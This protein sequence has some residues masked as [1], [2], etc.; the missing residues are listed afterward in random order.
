[1]ISS[2]IQIWNFSKKRHK[3]FIK[4][5]IFSFIMGIFA[6]AQMGAIIYAIYVLL[7]KQPVNEGIKS[8]V[9]MMIICILG[10]FFT[11]YISQISIMKTGMFMVSDKRMTL[12]N[13]LRNTNLGFFN[14]SSVG[15]IS[16]VLTT[17]LSNVEMTAPISLINVI[18]GFLSSISI[19]IA[20]LIYEWHIGV[21]TAIGMALY[22]FAVNW[23]MK[24]SKRD[25]PRRQCA[26]DNLAESVVSFLQG[27]KV[28]KSFSAKNGDTRLKSTINESRNENIRLTDKSMFS[29]VVTQLSIVLFEVLIIIA[30][31]FLYY[32]AQ[33]ISLDTAIVVIVMSFMIYAP[34]NQAGSI[35]S[36]IGMLDSAMEDVNELESIEQLKCENPIDKMQS[37]EI[38]FDNVC[39]S[40]GEREVLHNISTTIKPES[41]TAIIGPSGSGKSTICKLVPRFWDVTSGTIR[42]GGVDIR[43]IENSELMNKISMVFQNTYLFE[44]TILNN[45]R[46]GKKDATLQEVREAARAAR[47]D[48][49]IMSL[50]NGYDTLIQ[51]GGNSLSGG[52]KQRISIARAILKNAPIIIL[53][54][55]TSALDSKNEQDI[56]EAID[57][58]TKNKTVIMIA[59]R[60]K[61][62]RNADHIIA[63]ENGKIVQEGNHDKL[64]MQDGIYS[65][66]LKEREDAMN[67]KIR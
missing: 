46:F 32:N 41:L 5:I 31:I 47:C 29:Q 51:E 33:L 15:K 52:E 44:D 64:I 34:I 57:E 26:Q 67:W 55:A 50:P 24:I 27:I 63:I 3:D 18:G 39:F 38:V 6:M 9:I 1:M 19:L 48:D 7:N 59:H 43:H 37:N 2:F 28:I 22:I 17:T 13:I 21:I 54:E 20:M 40:Y 45:I 25:A 23:Q 36:M 60:M 58:L 62:V 16:S 61:T 66:F 30:A 4:S 35:L 53:D 8:V 56:L 11:S 12:G 42:I 10:T 49:F 14:N 65:R